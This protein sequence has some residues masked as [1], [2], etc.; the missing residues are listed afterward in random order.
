MS[1]IFLCS[2]AILSG[3]DLTSFRDRG[4]RNWAEGFVGNKGDWVMPCLCNT[5]DTDS[6]SSELQMLHGNL[7]KKTIGICITNYKFSWQHWNY[8]HQQ[9][10]TEFGGFILKGMILYWFHPP[11]SHSVSYGYLPSVCLWPH[12]I[13]S[14][15]KFV[16]CTR[17]HS[18]TVSCR[19]SEWQLMERLF[20]GVI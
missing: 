3:T 5:G 8:I 20:W 18:H 16:V 2:Q 4:S 11:F 17:L 15:G 10:A 7:K 13:Q 9:C 14:S 6:E 19:A 12:G 1:K